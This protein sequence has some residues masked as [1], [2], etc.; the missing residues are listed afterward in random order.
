[1]KKVKL[2]I[3][4]NEWQD[5]RSKYAPDDSRFVD[6]NAFTSGTKNIDTEQDGTI[7][8]MK[9]GTQFTTL[10]NKASDQ[11]E[12]IFSDGARHLLEVE[13]G[14]L[15]FT[16]GVASMTTV[17]SGYTAS[18]NFEFATTRNR[19]YFGNGITN[20]VYDKTASY[21][22]VGYSVPKTKVMGAQAP[23]SAATATIV[24]GAGVPVGGHTYKITFLY[25]D[26]EESNGSSASNLVTIVAGPNQQVDLSVI[27]VGGYGVT[28]RKI[29]RDNNDG[30]YVLVGTISNNTATTFSDNAAAG[31]TPIP[32]DNGI[33]PVFGQVK[34][35][36]E[37]LWLAQ[38][39]GEPFTLYFSEAGFPDIV[40]STNFIQ[41]NPEDPITAL[42]VYRGRL[43]IFNRRSLG[44]ILGDTRDSF[45]YDPIEGSVGCVDSRTV[46]EITLNGVPVVIWLSDKGFYGFNGSSIFYLSDSIEDLLKTDVKQTVIQR[47]Q[48]TDTTDADFNAGTASDGIEVL[49]GQVTTEGFV[50]GTPTIGN[51]PKRTWDDQ[52][53]WEGGDSLSNLA[54]IEQSNLLTIPSNVTEEPGTSGTRNGVIADGVGITLA[55]TDNTTG[56]AN[57]GA[58]GSGDFVN[59]DLTAVRFIAPATGIMIDPTWVNR[60]SPGGNNVNINEIWSD[61]LGEPGTKLGDAATFTVVKDTVYWLVQRV[62]LNLNNLSNATAELSGGASLYSSNSGAIWNVPSEPIQANY[63]IDIAPIPAAGIWTSSLIDTKSTTPVPLD[64][65]LSG[66]YPTGTGSSTTI[67]GGDTL[68]FAGELIV[69]DTQSI[70]DING[71]IALTISSRRYYQVKVTLTTDDSI[72]VPAITSAMEFKF[73]LPA[74]WISDSIDTTADSTVYNSLDTVSTTP[75][76]STVVTEIRTATTEGGLPAAPWVAFGAVTVRQWAQMRLT[77]TKDASDNIPSVTSVN[78]TWTLVSNLI[79]EAIDT[80]VTPTGWDIFQTDFDTN[81]GTVLHELRSAATEGG[82]AGASWFTVTNGNFPTASLP[83]LQW[84]QWRVTL[85]SSDGSVPIVRNVLIKWFIGDFTN[86]RAASIFDSKNYYVAL[87]E[88][89]NDENNIIVQLDAKGKWRIK[90]GLGVN[91]FGFF[92]NEIYFGCSTSAVIGKFLEGFTDLGTNIEIDI[93]TRAFDFSE[94]FFNVSEFEKVP[95]SIILE[96]RGTGATYDVAYSLDNGTTFLSFIDAITGTSTFTTTNDNKLFSRIFRVNA[97]I[98][99]FTGAKTILYKIHTDDAFDIKLHRV[100]A[101]AFITRKEPIITG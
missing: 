71:T 14:T 72:T 17:T 35:F 94:Q 90:R 79:S 9:G 1:M 63:L 33:P 42:F 46:Q 16:S 87:A 13:N 3:P 74:E 67:E 64:I 41:C 37:R 36:L 84:V 50:D 53:D 99:G 45:A 57:T 91:T 21:G 73:A 77:L 19:V 69:D 6:Q 70:T 93:R 65:T 31:T 66:T 39:S 32:T 88:F 85:T 7:R 62:A 76:S 10:S 81:G 83:I 25:Y 4:T 27:P 56:E 49:G 97:S 52:T 43:L 48:H 96:G 44:Q 2:Q 8:K 20:Q 34:L 18:A 47:N 38:I 51:N 86:L 100:K 29:Y 40:E 12:A 60:F 23:G 24:A 89:G 82:L 61:G 55:T 92:F 68:N 78:F 98:D 22:G 75:G 30:V 28:D 101:T 11:H 15:K 58:P 5:I 80:T 59:Q 26:F 54:T 95:E